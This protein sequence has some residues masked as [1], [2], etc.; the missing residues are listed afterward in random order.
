MRL[1]APPSGSR[2]TALTLAE[3]KKLR[4]ETQRGQHLKL[5]RYYAEFSDPHQY[6]I[7]LP[8]TKVVSICRFDPDAYRKAENA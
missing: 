7:V 2:A 4:E 5:T 6:L 3:V 1:T 8:M